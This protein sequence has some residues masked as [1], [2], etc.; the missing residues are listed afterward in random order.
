MS[1]AYERLQERKKK[2]N[3]TIATS[4]GKSNSS[5]YER[6]QKRKKNNELE[7]IIKFDTLDSDLSSL[8]T[9]ISK[10]YDGWQTEETMKNTRSA[11]E[12][13]YN[14]LTSY[15]EY[16]KN[17]GI[18]DNEK[19]VNDLVETYKS[20]LDGWDDKTEIYSGFKNADAYNKQRKQWDLSAQ[21]RVK[22][23][24]N[25]ETGEDEYR[26][27]TFDEVQAKLKEYKPDTEEYKFLSNYTG[28]TNL[29]DFEKAISNTKPLEQPKWF[30]DVKKIYD[31]WQIPQ[32][33]ALNEEATKKN[34]VI[35]YY[36][37][38]DQKAAEKE[39]EEYFKE[40]SGG[41]TFAE[42]ERSLEVA[43]KNSHLEELKRQRNIWKLDNA[44]DLLD[45]VMENKD[46]EENSKYVSTKKRT[47]WAGA[48]VYEDNIYE[49]INDVDGARNYVISLT[50]DGNGA[51]PLEQAG[52]HKLTEDEKKVYNYWHNYDRKN[53]TNK[54]DEFLDAMKITLQKRVNDDSTKQ[55]DKMTDNPW[56][57]AGISLTTVPA[58]IAGGI[59]NIIATTG[60][61]ITGEE[62]NPYSPLR[63]PSNFATDVRQ[64]VGEDIAKATEGFEVL[65]QNIPSFLYQTGMSMGDTLV[66]GNGLGVAYSFVAGS[67]AYQQKAKEMKEAGEDEGTIFATAFASGAAEVIFE[68]LS[69]EKLFSIKN[70]D[71]KLKIIKNAAAQ[72]GFEGSEEL[73]TEMANI[74]SDIA[75]RGENSEIFQFYN[76]LKDRGY[77]EGEIRTEVAKKIGGQLGWAFA[78]GFASGG[79]LGGITSYNQ[80]SQNRSKGKNI[81]NNERTNE[82]F[83]IASLT[84]KET[85][86]YKAYTEYA[87][88]GITSDNIKDAQLGNLYHLAKTES[89]DALN[90]RKS[91]ETQK[92]SAFKTLHGL[93]ALDKENTDAKRKKELTIGEITEVT[94]T[95]N[96]ATIEGIKL[97]GN[98]TTLVTNEGEM[99]VN[100]ITLSDKDADLVVKAETIGKEYG[101][102]LGNLFLAQYD[103]KTDIEQY[104][105]SFNLAMEYAKHNF[106]QGAMLENRGVLSTS[107]VKA[108]HD[109]TVH[110]TFV[111]QD[112]RI[113]AITKKQGKAQF[114]KG[115]VNDSIIDYDGTSTDGSKVNWSDLQPNQRRAIK[116][117]K[118][119]AEA[120]GVNIKFIKSKVEGG[121]HKG[122]NG[123]YNP[124]NNTIE[125]DVYAG[126]INAKDVN[127]SIIPTLSHEITHWMKHKA[128]TIYE[129]I[130]EDVMKTLAN[131]ERTDSKG[132]KY[133]LTESELVQ[134]E[135]DRI[136]R[137]HPE[138]D[139]TPEYA[140]DELV[141]RAC[142]D[143]LSN[144]N[145]A[146]KL[147]A[148]MDATEQQSFIDKVKETFE[149]LIQWVND[150]LAQYS[151]NS[152]EA[153]IL[154]SYKHM[155]KKVSKQWD[156][157]LVSS[158]EVSNALKHEGVT[159]EELAT[160]TSTNGVQEMAREKYWYPQMSIAELSY[161][162]RIAKYELSKTDNYIDNGTK[163]LYNDK[164]G[165]SFFAL[166]STSD[167]NDP[168]ILYACKETQAQNEYA[169][170]IRFIETL[171]S[172]DNGNYEQST[173]VLNQVLEDFWND[174]GANSR[175]SGNALGRKSNSRN[176]RISNTK[177]NFRPSVPLFDCLKNISKVQERNR[178][179]Q[180]SDRDSVGN[181][182][183]K[184]QQEF[185]KDSKVRDE[186]GNLLVMYHGT[187][188]ATFT[189]FRSGTY[190]TEHKWYADNYQNQGASSLSYKKTADNP[191]TYA[192]YLDIKKPFD[193][194]NKKERDIWYK[195][196]YLARRTSTDLKESGL[197]DW[198]DGEDLQE[199][200]EE[201]GYDYD[202][203]ILD[204]GATGG[205]GEEVISRGLSYVI[206]N[207]EQVK[208][209]DNKTPTKDADYR[210]S[211]RDI[212]S[213]E[214]LNN[215]L[216]QKQNE[217]YDLAIELRKFNKKEAQD[218]LYSVMDK[219]GVTQEELNNALSE[220][221]EWERNSGY[222][223]KQEKETALK[224][225]LQSL[226]REIQKIEDSLHK[227]LLEQISHFTDE[228]IKKYVSKAVRRYHT[229]SRLSNAS[230]LLTTGNMLDFS[231]GQGYRVKDHREISEILDLPEYAEYSDGMIAF[232]NMGNIR[233]QTYGIDISQAPNQSQKTALRN[234]IA[235]VM[236]ENDEFSVDF[237]KSNGYTDG[238]VTYPKGTATTKILSDIDNYFK[239]GVV[240]EYESSIAKFRYSDRDYIE[241]NSKAVM[242]A[243]RIDYLIEDSGA[244][245][246]VDYANYWITSI[247]PTDFLNMTLEKGWQDRSKFDKY[248]SEWNEESTVDTYDYIGELKKNMRQT[249]YLAIDITTGKVDGHEGRHRMRALEKQGIT[250]VEIRVEFRDEDGR[251][252]KY[253]PDG[254]RLQIKDILKIKNQYH[255]NQSTTLSNII[256]L[257]KDYRDEIL[258][259]Y[260]ENA[261]T[262]ASLKYSDRDNIS[263]YD[264]MGETDRLI[265]ENEQL[266]EDVDRLKE[267]LKI[268]RQVAHERLKL[269][270]QVTHG[271][272]FNENQLDAVA[273]HIRKLANSN[274]A[275]KDLVT[276]INGIYQYIAHSE[277]LNWQD[278]F[279]Q[280]YDVARMVL[281]EAKPVTTPN[282]Y[283]RYVLK[284][285]SGATLYVDEHQIAEA[286]Y[287]YGKHWRNKLSK[288]FTITTDKNNTSI[289]SMWK[290][291]SD[292]NTGYPDIFDAELTSSSQLSEL[293]DIVETLREGSEIIEEY[294][295]EE[296]TRWIAKEIYNQYWNVSPIRTTADKYD[297]QIK[298]L[299]YEHR[300]VMQKVRDDYNARLTK[301]KQNDKARF[302]ETYRKIRER[303]DKEIAEV[304]ELGKKRMDAYKE[305][306][307]RKTKIQS[308]TSNAL[309][310]NK[311][312]VK[313]SKD[314]HIHEA[315]KGP[316]IALLNAIDFSSKQLLGMEGTVIEKR[317]T[318]TKTDISLS[319]ALSKV[320][321]MMYDASVGKEE[322]VMLYGH[323]LN[324]D[325]KELVESVDDM[326]S[327]VGDNEFVLN[328]MSLDELNTLDKIVTTIRHSVTKMNKFHTVNHS[329]GIANL[330]QEE[331]AYA[332]KLGKTKVFDPATMK[333][334][335]RKL[336]SWDN[337]V[338]YYAF[339]RF[340]E[341]GQKIFEAFQ[342]GW[343]KLSFHAKEIIDFAKKTYT[344][345]EI[346]EWS[347]DIKSFDVLIPT[348]DAD[349]ATPNFKP[350][351]QGVQMS[352][353]Q[354]MSLY[355]LSKREQ[356][357]GHM[358]GGGIRVADIK[359][360]NGEL[361]QQS[362]GA[363]LTEGDIAKIINTLTDRQKQVADALQ[364]FMNTVCSDWG[365]EVSMARFGYLAFGEKNYFPI[366]S[367]NN[368]L[369]VPDETQRSNDLFKLLN[370]SFTKSLTEDANNRIVISDIFDVFA[371]HSSDMAKY[372]AL[373]L[374]VLDAFRWYNYKEKAQQ[375]ETQFIT[376]SVKQS[377]ENAFGKEGQNYITTFLK[378]INGQQNVSRDS[379]GKTFF[380]RA[381]IVSVAANLRV[382]LLQPTAFLKASAVMKNKYLTKA[383]LH[384][385]KMKYA[386]K[387]CGIALWKSLGYYDTD[388]SKG[389][390]EKIKHDETWKDKAV[391]ISLK[392]A[393]W[394]DKIT[395]G[396]LWNA[397][398]L[399][400]RDTR[401]DLKVGSDEF[402]NAI[403]K[404][405]REVIYAT[406]VVDSTMTRSQMMRSGN[407]YEKMLT[408]YSSEPT[409]AY[410]MLQ[411]VYMQGNLEKRANGKVSQE[412]L[413]KF[414]KVF[415]AYTVTNIVAALIESGFDAFR[416]DD[417]EEM[418]MAEFM[419]L[420]LSN[421]AADMSITAK[422]PLLKEAVSVAQGFTSSRSDTE[423]MQS[424]GYAL[425]GWVK[426]AQGDGNPA[427]TI[428]HSIRSLTYLSGLPFYNAYRDL[429]ATLDKLEILTTED[430]EEIFEDL[431]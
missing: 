219:E 370:M 325:I 44:F 330:S 399:E 251:I 253:S 257:N 105:T 375:G 143:M 185:F 117:A 189:K 222:A 52:Y 304:R 72:A 199:F 308:I 322:L 221:A 146:R 215:Q 228:E 268:E 294:D 81:R 158:V 210:F 79:G 355:C 395:F 391:E 362:E 275:K 337:S 216:R 299:N 264:R 21:F 131:H 173:R 425:K 336:L 366:Q 358:L 35:T 63:T 273:G 115:T 429:M 80:Y 334:K 397:C 369:A 374:P 98:N 71:S 20:I 66:G 118:L 315:M 272:Y 384:K 256:P 422:I 202:G 94:A 382:A 288:R 124:A 281:D 190:F 378:D 160:K 208:S 339:K 86:A 230:Y 54:A 36:T 42:Y 97:S 187:P 18:T 68:Y 154:S 116:F 31:N 237:S 91:S 347:K 109:A 307:E 184:E 176:V 49:F 389:L 352:V 265:K 4:E 132:N 323:D 276:L 162:R 197:V 340:G 415:T 155:L 70:V 13:M 43:A 169:W 100:D 260:G 123:S 128:S 417:D 297:K 87:S 159:A 6:L 320:K 345:K 232:M 318:P 431:F 224:D 214:T 59:G 204:E 192:V 220:Y 278:L 270:R 396:Y 120:T 393:E 269:E 371:Q 40:F 410:N 252:I 92:A 171:R 12:S 55:W 356:A 148:K 350:K 349:L 236:R 147:L 285:I 61:A 194:R 311:W 344:E 165:I 75:I 361:I 191:D 73:F 372:N 89:I 62:Y 226:R 50:K 287:R 34:G 394:G 38:A 60:E 212:K 16:R 56:A 170:F 175:N 240:P 241:T 139:V 385:P 258:T 342:D 405:L 348:T 306:A 293:I 367:D 286:E 172:V 84:P 402:F 261:N 17:Y 7:G 243:E 343:D 353:P 201:K 111:E 259:H 235:Q 242:T 41:K 254:K 137:N 78:G 360:K 373:A 153:Q 119:F 135:M 10:A 280:C 193:T 14:R 85:E 428:K 271:N 317:G 223:D 166:Y 400:I 411:D 200:L 125:I 179:E 225:E 2:N 57:A 231:D 421:F 206:F 136:K 9:T 32:A 390:T 298:R 296:R 46:F 329:K 141:A 129:S 51:T 408:A 363:V 207:P 112:N 209:V 134:L 163:W 122:E 267:R 5:A 178:L 377:I 418:D 419:K 346:Q 244:G 203:L 217:I 142:E 140:I 279:A 144:S 310:L 331:I 291:W 74:F 39:R 181:T 138:M 22:T 90:S 398:E 335:V 107:Q 106:T 149:N 24:T 319:K 103:G 379:L 33:G 161:V 58:T 151:S 196:F 328:K 233:L 27:L 380:T 283:Y 126:R 88:K 245:D 266:K 386:E 249:P 403:G 48:P 211:D 354:I 388:I 177:T 96:S 168:T 47:N 95:G 182:L 423:W 77:N 65:G 19:E 113:K 30:A 333:A 414:V 290:D 37:G 295:I 164:K 321:D 427:S 314:E 25:K 174:Y 412:T 152:E 1:S 195:E 238:S 167:E 303:K 188:N 101:E 213:L 368:N 416:D 82:M 183:T 156:E 205:Y 246:R 413:K 409:L 130:R 8:G 376:K 407:T 351:Y 157:M 127:D 93:S 180:Y 392:G 301:Q 341:A 83:E 364:E 332:D 406:Q 45:D 104:A 300:K 102:E 316:V 289:D 326:M 250:S 277:D 248:P 227:K 150:L 247:S 28:Y 145:S 133:K 359:L 99:S 255:T 23:G 3:K 292:S 239:T 218:K 312:L 365:N 309:T 302:Q 381:K 284:Q 262:N 357:K 229:T 324:D 114:I 263:V 404:R 274:Y 387:Y 234:I 186:N 401:K 383:F 53:K 420:Y 305:R 430:L 29:E 426:V 338:P 108:I 282:D 26:G 121:K 76:D 15:Q 110:A 198:L 313:N 64:Y 424:I 11:I 69:L 67:S 327:A